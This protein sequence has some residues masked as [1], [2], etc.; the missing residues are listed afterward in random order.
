RRNGLGCEF[1][2]RRQTV[3]A[4][5]LFADHLYA[6]VLNEVYSYLIRAFRGS[7]EM[8]VS[9]REKHRHEAFLTAGYRRFGNKLLDRRK[10]SVDLPH[11]IAKKKDRSLLLPIVFLAD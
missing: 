5:D 9:L 4:A 2:V 8:L 11:L 7:R 1:A 10:V 3:E 6:G